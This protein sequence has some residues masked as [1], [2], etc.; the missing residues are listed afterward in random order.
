M[1]AVLEGVFPLGPMY[2]ASYLLEHRPQDEVRIL[3]CLVDGLTPAEVNREV[4]SFQPDILG[5]S[6]MSVQAPLAHEIAALIKKSGTDT[7]VII[8]GPHATA[9]PTQ[10]LR[11]S[12]IDAVALGEGEATFLDFVKTVES[13]RSLTT[14]PGLMLRG[15]SG[16]I[17]TTPP[18]EPIGD[19]DALPYPAWDLAGIE[20]FF[21]YRLMTPNNIRASERCA[22]VFTSRA[23]PYRC[24]YCH[25]IFGKRFRAR[26]PS[27]VLDEM[28]ILY[29]KYGVREFHITDDCFNLEIDRARE[30][31]NGIIKSGWDIKIAFPNGIR[32]DRLPDD[33]LELMKRAGVYKMNFGI[34]SG[35]KRI[36]ELIRK[37][38]DLDVVTDAIN[39]ADR[40]GFITHGFFM[41]GFPT[42][43]RDEI[44]QTIEMACSSR[45]AMAGFFFVTPYPG[46]ALYD[47]AISQ[48][49]R[50]LDI[51]GDEGCYTDVGV[52]LSAVP[53]DE[54]KRMHRHAYRRFYL[55]PLRMSRLAWRIPRKKDLWDV[56][57]AH[58][59]VKFV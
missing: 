22:T 34:E 4:E 24:I 27:S 17:V 46:T 48:G 40:M 14:A 39:R 11:D 37:N 25:N 16:E 33:L 57:L 3:D 29:E 15:E 5:I 1:N 35:S 9:A 13:H 8:G 23:C 51:T 38:L 2:L 44:S 54:L 41:I 42:E 28:K 19:L 26:S 52:N 50:P 32:A 18:R 56:F 6:A 59:K 49:W 43:T 30:I 47:M 36:Q 7:S 21:T 53:D 12:N 10:I 45:L 20:K 31:M 58:W 55:N